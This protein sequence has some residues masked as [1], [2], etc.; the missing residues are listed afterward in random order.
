[1]STAEQE[2]FQGELVD[3]VDEMVQAW[4]EFRVAYENFRIVHNRVRPV[5]GRSWEAYHD[6]Q[7]YGE[8]RFVGGPFLA[9]VIRQIAES[10]G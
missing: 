2:A 8:E 7:V 9:D 4:D 1:M 3:A 5:E 6:A 10:V